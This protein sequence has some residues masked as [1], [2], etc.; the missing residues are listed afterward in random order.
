[1]KQP[2][3]DRLADEV[4]KT[5]DGKMQELCFVFP[6]R[7]AGIFFKKF[8]SQKLQKPVWSPEI[9]SIEDFIEKLSPYKPADRLV[10]IFELYEI[11][12]LH[13]EEESFDMF[14]PWGEMMLKDFDEIDK[15]LVSGK[16]IFKIVREL[17]E[18]E[19]QLNFNIDDIE[20]FSAFWKTFSNK[21]LSAIQSE[22]IKTWQV[23]GKVYDDFRKRL[24]DKEHCL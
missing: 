15:N 10:L 12:K 4:I 2:F 5:Y 9:Y 7:R 6:S 21:E 14:Y 16:D 11:Y 13:G 17:R 3:L 19:E 20:Q 8:L 22:F 24:A 18:V 23:L 1:M